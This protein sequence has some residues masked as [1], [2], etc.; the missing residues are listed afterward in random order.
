[1]KIQSSKQNKDVM[2]LSLPTEENVPS[3]SLSDYSILLY[4]AK[5]IGKTSVAARFPGAFFL[6]TEPGT[7]ALRVYSRPVTTWAEYEGY[8]KLLKGGKHEFKTVVVDT[9]DL[10]YEMAFSHVCKKKCIAH[11][12]EENDFGATW[13][14]I[15]EKFKSGVM[16]LLNIP[17]LGVIFIS[18]DVEKEIELRDGTKLDRVQPTMA[19]QAMSVVEAVVDVIMNYHYTKSG[20]Y[21]RLDGSHDT[22]AGCRIEEHFIRKGGKPRMAGDRIKSISMGLTAQEA[23]D[24]LM[25]AFNNEQESVDPAV[26]KKIVVSTVK[27]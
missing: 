18:H 9:I 16:G 4:G 14:E 2:D 19:R 6:S 23:Y 24:N 20:R 12:N 22:V 7:K 27:K 1:M 13:K 17:N 25:S 26:P 5:K 21:I 15:T 10:L 3:S 11:P 8:L